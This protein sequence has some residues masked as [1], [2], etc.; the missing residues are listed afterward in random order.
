MADMRAD[1]EER[2]KSEGVQIGG[3]GSGRGVF[4]HWFDKYVPLLFLTPESQIRKLI[5]R[6]NLSDEGPAGPTAFWKISN[7]IKEERDEDS[8]EESVSD[9]NFMDDDDDEEEASDDGHFHTHFPAHI[10]IVS[11]EEEIQD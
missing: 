4:G 3:I 11:I 8:D 10:V 2:W 7:E 6:R 5:F 9:P 1:S